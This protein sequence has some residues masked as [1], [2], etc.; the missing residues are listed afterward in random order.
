MNVNEYPPLEGNDWTSRILRMVE[1][2]IFRTRFITLG[3]LLLATLYFAFNAARIQPDAGW[4]KSIPLD[5]PYMQTF[6]KYYRDFGGA[7][8]VLFALIKEEGTGDIYEEGFMEKLENATNDIFFMPGVDRARVMSIFTPNVTYVENIEGGLSGSNVIPADY[9]PTPEMLDKVKSN[10]GKAQVIGRLVTEDQRGALI[11]SELL[12]YDPDTGEKLDYFAVGDYLEELRAKYEQ[13]G[14]K[15]HIIGFA[16]IVHDMTNAALQVVLFFLLA[17]LMTGALLWAYTGNF[18]LAMLVMVASITAVIWEF[19]ALSALGYGLDPFSILV[20]FLVLAV[21]VSH[22]VQY[23]NAWVAE[24][25]NGMDRFGASLETFR[26]LAIPGTVA[27]ITDVAGFATIYLINIAVIREMSINAALGVAAIII[28]NKVL[29]P[30]MLTFIEIKNLDKFKRG[31]AARENLL[32]PLWNLLARATDRGPAI[33]ILLISALLLGWSVWKYPALKIGDAIEGVPELRPDSRFNQD[34]RQIIGNFEIGVDQ[35]KVIAETRPNG[36]VDYE[37]MRQID[38]FE[39]LM[40]AQDGVHSTMSLLT[41]AKL[42]YQ[43]LSEGRLNALVLPRNKFALAQATALVPTTTGILND[44]CD[45]MAIFIFTTD[46]KA[47]TISRL[48]QTIKDFNAQNSAAFY[49]ASDVDAEYCQTKRQLF[50]DFRVLE[51]EVFDL[52]KN[53]SSSEVIA[54]AKERR[55]AIRAEYDAMDQNCPV[56]FAL[57]SGNVGVMAATNEVVEE[58]ELMVVFW[59]YVVLIIFLW[60]SFRSVAGVLCVVLPLSLVSA[61]AYAVMA[62]LDIG[63]KVATLPVVALAVGIGVDYG[64]YVYSETAA[65]LNQ[66]RT[67][68]ES[69]RFTLGRTGK[70]VVFIGVSLGLSVATWLM[71]ELQFQIDMGIML[72]FMFTANMF[73]AI[74]ILPA[75]ARFLLK[76]KPEQLR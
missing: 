6:Q 12:E 46:H 65:A 64:I 5:H 33:V 52:A 11:V 18:K 50:S 57:A 71:S 51:G 69:F 63:L 4:L 17:L 44:D 55:D 20:P 25:D 10:V 43:G 48:V 58:Q 45:A 67:L 23:A 47:E 34:F 66:G 60:L 59:V 76:L 62:V 19:G 22:G 39:W 30:I 32:A 28:T 70:A 3:L 37:L 1:P 24:I 41:Y 54:E 75:L 15:V 73:G 8:S 14:V 26:R 27:L 42:V 7:N 36:C 35:L 74:L 2:P 31:Q 40:Q 53:D 16:K 61:M 9:S 72:M 38:E 13:D 49:A 68:K 21:S 29:M 56:E